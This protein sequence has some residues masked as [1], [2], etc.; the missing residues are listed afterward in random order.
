[1]GSEMCIRDR[2][3]ALARY[4]VM[5]SHI[6]H[7]TMAAEALDPPMGGL[8]HVEEANNGLTGGNTT[9]ARERELKKLIVWLT[10]C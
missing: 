8:G 2:A 5:F 1:M 3:G 4:F 6:G 7:V 10:L 9:G